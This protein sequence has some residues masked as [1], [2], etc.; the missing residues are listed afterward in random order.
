ML[1]IRGSN[2]LL[3]GII[4]FFVFVYENYLT[5]LIFVILKQNHIISFL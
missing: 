1:V 2:H 4:Y 3:V 5:Y